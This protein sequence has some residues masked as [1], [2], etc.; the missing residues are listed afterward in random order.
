MGDR[1]THFLN[2]D[3]ELRSRADLGP[4]VAAVDKKMVVLHSRRERGISHASLE[5]YEFSR[6]VDPDMCIARFVQ[7]V[8]RLPPSARRVW[9]GA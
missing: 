8:R 1:A 6:Y 4:L 7:V 9:D 2:V 3:L 5:L